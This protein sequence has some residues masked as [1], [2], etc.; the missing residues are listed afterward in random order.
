MAKKKS[1]TIIEQNCGVMMTDEGLL[2]PGR[3]LRQMGEDIVVSVSSHLIVIS[4]RPVSSPAR[5]LKR[6]DRRLLLK[7]KGTKRELSNVE[8]K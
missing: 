8:G 5:K 2:I 1:L 3:L 4:S 7:D 6:T